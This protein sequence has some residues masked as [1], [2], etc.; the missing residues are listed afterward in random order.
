MVQQ[1]NRRPDHQAWK[2]GATARYYASLTKTMLPS[3]KSVQ[4]F[5]RQSDHT[6]TLDHRKETQTAVV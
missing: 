2:L 3:R 1:K 6:K 4:R 5:S